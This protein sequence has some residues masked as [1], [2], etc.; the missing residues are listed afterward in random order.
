LPS[1]SLSWRAKRWLPDDRAS[2]P[3][4]W[5]AVLGQR[6]PALGRICNGRLHA[7]REAIVKRGRGRTNTE[8]Q[9]KLREIIR[10]YEDGQITK[11]DGYTV[12]QAVRDWHQFGMSGRGESTIAKCT[13]LANTHLIPALGGRK[14]RELSAD[15]VD[16]WLAEKA[17]TLST[18]TLQILHSILRRSITRAQARDKVKR[19][20]VLLCDVPQGREGRPSKSLTYDLWG[21]RSLHAL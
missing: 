9:R 17:K 7:Q 12:A 4:R 8:A 19:N 20:V 1:T 13:I 21:A 6:S 18:D 14:L 2:K 3:G 5:R 16:R 10:D 15:D 11:S